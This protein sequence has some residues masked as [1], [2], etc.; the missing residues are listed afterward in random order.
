MPLSAKLVKLSASDRDSRRKY[1]FPIG[2]REPEFVS[3][4]PASLQDMAP[5]KR[6][7][8]RDRR[9][10]QRNYVLGKGHKYHLQYPNPV[11]YI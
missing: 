3:S 9:Q 10:D 11:D 4:A 2:F 5:S 8:P 1:E 7:L 6:G